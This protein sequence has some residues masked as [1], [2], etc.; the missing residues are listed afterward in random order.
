MNNSESVEI[1]T[2]A[3]LKSEKEKSWFLKKLD[4]L[5]KDQG[6][7]PFYIAFSSAHRFIGSYD[8]NLKDIPET[9]IEH[10]YPGFTS[11]PWTALQIV[12][13]SFV[14]KLDSATN[15]K[16]LNGL[17]STADGNE[18]VV[19][20]RSLSL[21]PNAKDFSEQAREGVR[22][23]MS[24]VF[25]S[26]ALDNPYPAVHFQEEA[27]NQMVLKAIFMERPIFRIYGLDEKA[28]KSLAAIA[29]NF[30]H[31]RWAAGRKVSPELWRLTRGFIDQGI[32]QDLKRVLSADTPLA[33]EAAIRTIIES[34]HEEAKKWLFEK[35][36][37]FEPKTW[38]D[39]GKELEKEIT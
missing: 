3:S 24:D 18:L 8:V 15:H 28:N 5:E 23:N 19:L 34:D 12:R 35:G 2:K 31:E 30:A 16:I 26:I 13:L 32:F 4:T 9:D 38:N 29:S 11:L 17:F 7:R 37:T 1:I 36:L 20:Y 27:W 22:T 21:L 14:L 33:E 39:I 10:V 6:Q 25:D